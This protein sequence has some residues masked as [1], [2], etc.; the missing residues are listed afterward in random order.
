MSGAN[1][2]PIERSHRVGD[3]SDA[4]KRPSSLMRGVSFVYRFVVLLGIVA[5][6][7]GNRDVQH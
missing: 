6:L 5:Y 7:E 3:T 4:V 2:G 1:T